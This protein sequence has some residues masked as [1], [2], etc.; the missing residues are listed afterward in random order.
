MR[1]GLTLLLLASLSFPAGA[2]EREITVAVAS[3]FTDAAETIAR[4]FERERGI[5]V[6]L[7]FGS[8]GKHYAQIVQGAPYDAFLAADVRR[9][10]LLENEGRTLPGSRFTYAIGKLALWSTRPDLVDS[11]GAVLG[12]DRFRFVS[13][14][15]PR[16][17]PYGKAAEEV[18]SELGLWE[19]LQQRMVLGSNI[20]QAFHFV[21]SGNAEL[22]FVALSQI[23]RP[24]QEQAGSF[25]LP[26]Q[27]LYDRIE[28]QAVLL[29]DR[30]G[31][32]A[33]VDYL[34]SDP[35]RELIR[36]FGYEV[37]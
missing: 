26:P 6:L 2:D 32:R 15:N 28:Q 5:P 36:D 17:A 24:G 3:N 9:P 13:L 12:T 31:A 19:E 30:P 8:T 33:F 10:E 29:T 11:E 34:R 7:S 37:P 18:L 22:G 1:L 14:A 21:S 16:L 27:A 23:R 35:A 25:W 20:S 4:E